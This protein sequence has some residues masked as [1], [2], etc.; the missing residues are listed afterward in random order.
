MHKEGHRKSWDPE[1][2]HPGLLAK[3]SLVQSS[4]RGPGNSEYLGSQ[5]QSEIMDDTK[6][7]SLGEISKEKLKLRA[8]EIIHLL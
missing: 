8:K 3:Q 2:C 6:G 4:E 1:S 7:V 5:P